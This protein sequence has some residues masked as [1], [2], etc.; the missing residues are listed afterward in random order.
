MRRGECQQLG[1]NEV[2][3]N[4]TCIALD[5]TKKAEDVELQIYAVVERGMATIW[6]AD[7]LIW[8]TS[9]ILAAQ[10][11]GLATRSSPHLC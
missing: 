4:G 7:I 3:A 1:W 11:R 2:D 5:D 10:D 9:Q 6:N 8:A